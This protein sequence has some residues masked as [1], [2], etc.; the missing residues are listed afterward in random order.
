MKKIAIISTSYLPNIW[1]GHGRSTFATAFGLA[2]KGHEVSVFTFTNKQETYRQQDGQ[3]SIYFVGGVVEEEKKS[4]PFE[5]IGLWN[6]RMLPLL[7]CEKFDII[8]LNNWHGWEAAKK[9]GSAKIIS[10]VPFLYSFTGWLKPL[11]ILLESEIKNIENDF[12]L[13]SDTL[14]AHSFKFGNKL[15]SYI[16]RDVHIIPNCHLDMSTSACPVA[17][18]KIPNQICFVGRVNR[19][20]CLE[21]VIRVMPDLPNVQLVVVSPENTPGYFQ[22]L[23]LLAEEQDVEHRIKFLGWRRTKEVRD[24][25]RESS[26]AIVPS[27]FE[28]Y[29]YS[30]LDPMA[31]G[32][33]VIV[34]EW[35]MLGEYIDAPDMTFASLKTLQERISSI[36]EEPSISKKQILEAHVQTN[37]DRIESLYSEDYITTLLEQIL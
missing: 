34:S 14:I 11:P 7:L 4:L 35:S 37:K 9:Y 6:E 17:K 20:K 29:G 28:P 33:P 26:L 2:N 21:R 19:E 13:N 25:Y 22:G 27:Q 1:N 3:V 8:I 10:M 15:A 31:L 23:V 24:I 36:L 5:S 32:T 18:E 16:N 12:L 30:A